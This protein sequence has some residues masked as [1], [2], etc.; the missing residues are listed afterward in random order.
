MKRI[1]P[2]E[3]VG[4]EKLNYNLY[5]EKG[6]IIYKKGEPLTREFL[7]QHCYAHV[8]IKEI[9]AHLKHEPVISEK[10]AQT[11]VKIS[12][13]IINKIRE[14]EKLD[15]TNCYEAT[16]II[17]E[18]INTH[19]EK[20]DCIS[21]LKIFDEYTFSHIVNVSSISAAIGVNLG[22][23]EEALK[24]LAL[25]SLLHD[26]GKAFIP[27]HILNKPAKLDSEEYEIMKSHSLLGYRY[28]L[29]T[30]KL[31]DKIAKIA[32]DHQENYCGGGYPNGLKG[33][34]I[35]FNAQITAIADVYDALTSDRVYR[36]AV[37]TDT[38]LDIMISESNKRF[39][40]YIFQKFIQLVDY[41][42][43]QNVMSYY[44]SENFG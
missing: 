29:D 39:N 19:L 30:I 31:P 23:E 43:K 5:N 41:K 37:N 13:S 40:P 26:A 1:L 3:L 9:P 44:N 15:I 24:D 38:A 18:E 12:K 33:R 7:I 27:K 35:D 32:L 36:K 34:E 21:Q 17:L 16:D 42:H 10:V 11:L 2:L 14:C 22:L 20:I 25:G 28:I 4:N 6:Q 8:F